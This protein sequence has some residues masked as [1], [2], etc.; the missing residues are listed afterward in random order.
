MRTADSKTHSGCLVINLHTNETGPDV[1]STWTHVFRHSWS[2]AVL[3]SHR[4]ITK[5]QTE[6]VMSSARPGC[7]DSGQGGDQWTRVTRMTNRQFFGRSNGR[8]SVSSP[9]H[10]S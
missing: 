2:T 3:C 7:S 4:R 9:V 8:P 10:Q 6:L 1:D 5:W